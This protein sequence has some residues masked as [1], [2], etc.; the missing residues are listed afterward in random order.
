M[1]DN[2]RANAVKRYSILTQSTKGT[3]DCVVPLL[4]RAKHLFNKR[5]IFLQPKLCQNI[6]DLIYINL[7]NFFGLSPLSIG[8]K[9]SNTLSLLLIQSL[10]STRLVLPPNRSLQKEPSCPT[11]TIQ[12]TLT[13]CLLSTFQGTLT[14]CLLSTY[15]GICLT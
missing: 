12:G 11:S 9:A 13:P 5:L 10:T 8:R 3:M 6:R 2:K 4:C 14:P 1:A 7:S 15:Q